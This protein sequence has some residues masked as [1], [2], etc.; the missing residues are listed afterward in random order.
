[1]AGDPIDPKIAAERLNER[2]KGTNVEARG[3]RFRRSQR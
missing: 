2:A 3:T 1:M